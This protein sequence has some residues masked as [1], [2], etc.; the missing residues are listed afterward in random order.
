MYYNCSCSEHDLRANYSYVKTDERDVTEELV[1]R[2]MMK[3]IGL[4]TLREEE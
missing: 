2:Q 1:P 4:L 3:L